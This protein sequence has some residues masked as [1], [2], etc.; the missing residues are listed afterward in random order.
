MNLFDVDRPV[1]GMLH[2]PAL[3]GSPGNSLAL[4][5]IRDWVL[6]DAAA[7]ADGGVD[8]FILENFGDTPF[9]PARVP[10]HTVAY[11]AI[12]ARE[13]K[14]QFPKPLGINVLRNDGMAAMAVATAAGA[15]FIR[16]NVYTGARV[17]DQGIVQGEAHRIQR[18]RK[19]LGSAVRVFADVAV[20]HSA[21]L[22]AR[23][24]RDEVDD[25]VHR[26]RA[27]A[28]IVSG[29]GTGRATPVESLR[30]AK[31]AAGAAPVFAGSGTTLDNLAD[32]LASADGVIAGTSLKQDGIVTNRTDVCRVA[33]VSRRRT[34]APTSY[35][36]T[37]V[38]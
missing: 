18:Y 2:V 24:L 22:G 7:L 9:Y 21:P 38:Y 8:G 28:I 31:Q 23:D 27:D 36:L 20:K 6:R 13:V 12:L 3:P 10:R 37:F 17:T 35:W 16:V 15:D 29:A 32:V 5:E 34:L 1:I 11:L 30:I 26:G 19:Q 33:R 4:A 14:T 25:T